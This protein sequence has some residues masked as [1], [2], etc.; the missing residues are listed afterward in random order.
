MGF[1]VLELQP[2][3]PTCG[4]KWNGTSHNGEVNVTIKL[5]TEI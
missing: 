1:F 5:S 4:E 3:V 2:Q